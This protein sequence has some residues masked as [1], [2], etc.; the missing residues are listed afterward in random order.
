MQDELAILD[1]T[2]VGYVW[3]NK[4]FGRVAFLMIAHRQDHNFKSVSIMRNFQVTLFRFS[5][6][7]LSY[8][9][10]DSISA[11]QIDRMV[12]MMRRTELNKSGCFFSIDNSDILNCVGTAGE[13]LRMTA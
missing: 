13:L 5:S 9:R 3:K 12:P 11:D 1:E 2:L 8:Y 10:S 6:G 4:L 7:G